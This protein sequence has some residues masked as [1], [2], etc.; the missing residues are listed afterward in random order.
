MI[1]ARITITYLPTKKSMKIS[2]LELHLVE[3]AKNEINKGVNLD[4]LKNSLECELNDWKTKRDKYRNAL[5]SLE[6]RY[7]RQLYLTN[8]N[9]DLVVFEAYY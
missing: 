6:K 2:H 4:Q 3:L 9:L 8:N 7:A 1:M 5:T